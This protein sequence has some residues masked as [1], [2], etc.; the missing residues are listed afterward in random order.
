LG[1]AKMA[2]LGQTR[3]DVQVENLPYNRL[4]PLIPNSS[5]STWKRFGHLEDG[6]G[7]F[8]RNI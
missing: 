6:D 3:G 4:I 1:V 2:F 7:M 8:F 5:T